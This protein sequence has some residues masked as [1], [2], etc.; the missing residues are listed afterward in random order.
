MLS[1]AI[2]F[3]RL[4]SLLYMFFYC[5]YVYFDACLSSFI[6]HSSY[7]FTLITIFISICYLYESF[8]SI[9]INLL[10]YH[11]IYQSSSSCHT[12]QLINLHI[13]S[14]LSFNKSINLLNKSA[15]SANNI[16]NPANLSLNFNKQI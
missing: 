9:S 16:L 8:S 10:I 15:L 1:F 7:I 13:N 14:I 2:L 6:L 5:H 11:S 3:I 12:T 4:N